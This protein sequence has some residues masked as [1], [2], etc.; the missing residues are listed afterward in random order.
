MGVADNQTY[1][2]QYHFTSG[3]KYDSTIG[4]N[5]SLDI[6][7]DINFTIKTNPYRANVEIEGREVVLKPNLDGIFNAVGKRHSKGGMPVTLEEGSFV[8]SD[9]KTL[10]FN[11]DDHDMFELKSGSDFKTK[12]NTPAKVLKRNIDLEHYNRLVSNLTNPKENILAKSSSELM[13]KKYKEVVGKIA[14]AQESKKGFPQ[15]IPE[16]AKDSAPVYNDELKEDII[17]QK[18]YAKHGGYINNPYK[19]KKE[20]DLLPEMQT[21]GVYKGL[22][23]YTGDS[24]NDWNRSMYTDEQWDAFAEEVGFT[25][26]VKNNPQIP[27]DNKHFQQYLMQNPETKDIV[28]EIHQGTADPTGKL[29]IGPNLKVYTKHGMPAVTG[30]VDDSLL[31]KR[32]DQLV[33]IYRKRKSTPPPP[34]PP[35]VTPDPIPYPERPKDINVTPQ[36]YMP[37]DWQFTPWQ[38]MSQLYNLSRVGAINRYMPSRNQ[39]VSDYVSLPLY[40]PEPIVQDINA[41]ANQAI[42]SY[43]TLSPIQQ[44]AA[45]QEAVG[46]TLDQIN[47]VR[48][49]YDNRNVGQKTSEEMTNVQLRNQA[50][51]TNINFDQQYYREA[52]TGAA[53]YD[54]LKQA[55]KDLFMNNVMR[56]VE[57]NQSLAYQLATLRNPAWTYDFRT[58]NFKRLPKNILDAMASNN[59]SSYL[60]PYLREIGKN[61]SN[62]SSKDQIN[63]TKLLLARDFQPQVTRH[64]GSIGNPY[65]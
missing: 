8:F 62:M 49:D 12:N 30:Q 39:F 19:N 59:K 46:N 40:N 3:L 25:E 23:A 6:E 32:W 10:S 45:S 24:S 22:K 53:N 38:K 37:I 11:E 1:K 61:F 13:L 52:V 54:K 43:A 35:I 41:R 16:F 21:A 26:F 50:N 55:A 2:N 29:F 63:F 17:K 48:S 36:D 57:T 51:L 42:R 7:D 14:F 44:I 31:G 34:P 60:E 28:T 5:P 33:N 64:G 56:D 20:A 58:G 4:E 27:Y 18:Q 15:D 9:D 47:R 65:S